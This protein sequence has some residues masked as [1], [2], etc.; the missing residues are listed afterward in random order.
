MYITTDARRYAICD[1]C[2]WS[3]GGMTT[4]GG[5]ALTAAVHAKVCSAPIRV[6]SAAENEAFVATRRCACCA[7]D[8]RPIQWR[9]GHLLCTPCALHCYWDRDSLTVRP[10]PHQPTRRGTK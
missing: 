7:T 10:G 6:V 8:Q 2:R 3:S 4:A 1:A 9:L 5:Y